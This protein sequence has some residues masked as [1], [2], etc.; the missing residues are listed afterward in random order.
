MDLQPPQP[1]LAGNRSEWR[2]TV[3]GRSLFD[4]KSTEKM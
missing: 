4:V 3:T 2:L 1:M